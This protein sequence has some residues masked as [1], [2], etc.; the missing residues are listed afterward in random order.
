MNQLP[1]RKTNS[2][3]EK[4]QRTR[5]RMASLKLSRARAQMRRPRHS[6]KSDRKG[7]ASTKSAQ[8]PPKV[9]AKLGQAGEPNDVAATGCPSAEATSLPSS[10]GSLSAA[11]AP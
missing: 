8:A 1:K 6:G 10:S 11:K 9:R 5:R 7:S 3:A 4:T 2:K